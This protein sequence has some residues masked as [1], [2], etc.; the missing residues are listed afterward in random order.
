M[1]LSVASLEDIR[2]ALEPKTLIDPA[3]KVPRHY[4][5]FL[6]AFDQSEAINFPLTET[7]TTKSNSSLAQLH[8]MDLCTGCPKT[9]S[10]S[11]GNS[12]RKTLR[13]VLYVL[14]LHQQPRQCC[15]RRNQEGAYVFA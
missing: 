1:Y 4:H 13:K 10:L 6:K 7:A 9:S 5:E 8:P 2:K 3:T 14:A 12:F 11:S 15:L